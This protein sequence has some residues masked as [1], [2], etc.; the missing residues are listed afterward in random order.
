[1]A[2]PRTVLGVSTRDLRAWSFVA[3]GLG[4]HYLYTRSAGASP[5]WNEDAKALMFA[6]SA[7]TKP[8]RPPLLLFMLGEAR[9]RGAAAAAAWGALPRRRGPPRVQAARAA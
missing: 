4:C 5:F 7:L 3:A 2:P 6:L 1:M 8:P 9:R